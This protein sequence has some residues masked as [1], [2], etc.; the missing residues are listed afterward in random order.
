MNSKGIDYSK[1]DHI[2]D[3]S[4]DEEQ[5]ETIKVASRPA[6]RLLLSDGKKKS[7]EKPSNSLEDLESIQSLLQ[8][9]MKEGKVTS[10]MTKDL[11]SASALLDAVTP[12]GIQERRM[13][14]A[15]KKELA[16]DPVHCNLWNLTMKLRDGDKHVDEL[17]Q[18]NVIDRVISVIENCD[19]GKYKSRHFED[20][21]ANLQKHG[22]A[23]S[24]YEKILASR[25]RSDSSDIS[26]AI[27]VLHEMC[28]YRSGCVALAQHKKHLAFLLDEIPFEDMAHLGLLLASKFDAAVVGGL[29]VVESIKT[30][31]GDGMKYGFGMIEQC[32]I[33][34]CG[35]LLNGLDKHMS[36]RRQVAE[37]FRAKIETFEDRLKT[38]H[39][40]MTAY[41]GLGRSEVVQCI[42]LKSSLSELRKMLSSID[43][44]SAVWRSTFRLDRHLVPLGTS[45]AAEDCNDKFDPC[46]DSR[47][48][49]K[50][51]C[52]Q[53]LKSL[54]TCARW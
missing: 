29:E 54:K 21:Q 23:L 20:V 28:R 4:S 11:V 37:M 51:K 17:L 41:E 48:C 53:A 16:Y 27:S 10:I 31:W 52:T 12:N 30:D 8:K 22:E 43:S 33:D 19:P 47:K 15:K 25:L 42:N 36:L 44:T 7:P 6:P 39:L 34:M 38:T 9:C 45:H 3:T 1:F 13:A 50:C 26:S 35:R 18:V 2:G 40:T 46:P 14:A 49:S 24:P 5:D 32:T